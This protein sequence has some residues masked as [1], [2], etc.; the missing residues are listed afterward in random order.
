MRV[1]VQTAV[2][3]GEADLVAQVAHHVQGRLER[4]AQV[5]GL[6]LRDVLGQVRHQPVPEVL[7]AGELAVAVR[8]GELLPVPALLV[9]DAVDVQ[10]RAPVGGRL[11]RQV[12]RGEALALGAAAAV[13]QEGAVVH[14]LRL[15]GDERPQVRGE[16]DALAVLG[17]AAHLG[18][19]LRGQQAGQ[20]AA[21]RALL[22][23][24]A[25]VVRD[26]APRTRVQDGLVPRGPVDQAAVLGADE[27]AAAAGGEERHV[28]EEV[29]AE[30][31]QQHVLTGPHDVQVQVRGVGGRDVGEVVDPGEARGLRL[32][33]GQP[34][35][36]VALRH[37]DRVEVVEPGAVL[38]ADALLPAGAAVRVGH[39]H[40]PGAVHLDGDVGGG[41]AHDALEGGAQVA[42]VEGAGG[43]GVRAQPAGLGEGRR[44]GGSICL[45]GCGRGDALGP[46]VQARARLDRALGADAVVGV[47]GDLGGDRVHQQ[48]LGLVGAPDL[49]GARRRGVDHVDGDRRV[50]GVPALVG[51]Q[52]LQDGEAARAGADD[53]HLVLSLLLSLLLSLGP[54]HRCSPF[55]AVFSSRVRAPCIQ[56]T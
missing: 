12:A 1:A 38:E 9:L 19:L 48:V 37:H 2:V 10:Q 36:Y 32:A 21:V 4:S 34:G 33:G 45:C 35:R 49:A 56:A 24:A 13:L 53:G 23:L 16:A 20:V 31:A 52:A 51:A 11:Q 30:A 6:G 47:D 7:A 14:A 28:V 50:P 8:T 5:A 54:V 15:A 46:L 43:V 27:A 39:G 26:A 22:V 3:D 17:A 29:Q 40:G 42:A 25:G 55:W 44:V 41:A 18:D